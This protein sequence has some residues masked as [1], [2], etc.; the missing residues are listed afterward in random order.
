MNVP[1]DRL[2]TKTHEWILVDDDIATVGITDFAQSQLSDVTFV[3]L[4]STEDQ[5]AARD[6]VAVVESVKAASDVYSPVTGTVLDINENLVDHPEIIN[7]DPY[8]EGWMFKIKLADP[9]EVESFLD[10]DAYE[11]SLP[12]DS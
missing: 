1:K 10:A 3:E 2:Y 9:E 11:N 4:P 12:A 5:V 8:G 7:D 6:E